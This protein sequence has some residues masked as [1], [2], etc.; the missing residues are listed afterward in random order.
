MV[1]I[2]RTLQASSAPFYELGNTA[3]TRL[4]IS[5]LDVSVVALFY[6]LLYR[7]TPASYKPT[8]K[9]ER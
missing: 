7:D 1:D 5:C 4:I 6:F 8:L 3:R 9:Q 2:C